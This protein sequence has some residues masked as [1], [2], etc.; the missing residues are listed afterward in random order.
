[1][2]LSI[3]TEGAKGLNSSLNLIFLFILSF[4]QF[5]D[6]LANIYLFPKALG[7]NSDL[8]WYYLSIFIYANNLAANRD[9]FFIF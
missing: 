5:K 8:P 3:R 1:M 9:G 4:I 6:G 2:L 7:T